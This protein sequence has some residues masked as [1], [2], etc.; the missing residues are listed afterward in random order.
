MTAD[1]SVSISGP[2][3]D[4]RPR[5]AGMADRLLGWPGALIGAAIWV[6]LNLVWLQV[7]RGDRLWDHE[8]VT[9]IS[10][11]STLGSRADFLSNWKLLFGGY[12]PPLQSILLAPVQWVTGVNE[13]WVVWLNLVLTA[14]SGLTV[15]WIGRRMATRGAGLIAGA[16]VLCA[17]GMQE[18]ARGALTMVPATT[19]T[20][21][22]V[23]ALVAGR[24]FQSR[25]WS[26]VF[27]IAVG[28]MFLSRPMAVAFVPGLILAGL[29]W[30]RKASERSAVLRHFA[31]GGVAAIVASAWWWLVTFPAV[32]AYLTTGVPWTATD[33]RLNILL[34]RVLELGLY[35][36]PF[37]PAVAKAINY[38]AV[39]SAVLAFPVVLYVGL[40]LFGRFAGSHLERSDHRSGLDGLEANLAV[41]PLWVVVV[42]GVVVSLTSNMIGWLMLPVVPVMVVA[43]VV[44]VRRTLGGT[45]WHVW[46]TATVIPAIFGSLFFS[47]IS[48]TPGNRYTWCLPRLQITNA[49]VVGTPAA[50][51]DWKASLR[52]IS[53]EIRV[54]YQAKGI[55]EA[56]PVVAF[57]S[58]DHLF[59]PPAFAVQTWADHSWPIILGPFFSSE[60]SHSEQIDEV[61]RLAEIVVVV[62]DPERVFIYEWMS[63]PDQVANQLVG[64]GFARCA[65]TALPDGRVAEILVREPIPVG[66]CS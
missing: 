47:T 59:V 17:S 1:G 46:A 37:S 23:G 50:A 48:S 5:V 45:T 34:N 38:A 29:I 14:V 26:V 65:A 40:W 36:N 44:G 62:P 49:C 24:G 61:R 33:N 25:N 30:S 3:S 27:G 21:L 7:F 43:A 51:A 64:K 39:L 63:D 16:L 19:F 57:A 55:E 52:D 22:A 54:I 32:W 56:Q 13:A 66:V 8:E 6:A 9:Y 42:T 58:R 28:C 60:L 2:A 35:V 12:T 41:L 31:L 11:A 15:Y 4:D 18:N 53:D 20:V 10:R